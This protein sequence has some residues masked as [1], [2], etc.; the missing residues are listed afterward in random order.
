[1]ADLDKIKEAELIERARSGDAGSFSALVELYQQRAIHAANGLVGNLEDARDMAQEAFVKA[2][3][4]LDTFESQ[5]RFY[6]WFYRILVNTCRDFLRR[7][8][9]R[10]A[11]SFWLGKQEEADP[12]ANVA[13]R[14]ENA[15][16]AAE[17]RDLGR[18]VNEA[19]EKLPF[20]QR[21]VFALR[22]LEGQSLDEISQS[23]DIS[24]G[25]VKAH[26]WQACEKM[27]GILKDVWEGEQ[28]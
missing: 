3:E 14:A 1:V 17:H 18:V 27:R 11:F 16:D 10:G 25:A 26:L 7:Q 19:L 20:R 12:A 28:P 8:K 24:V 15:S 13:D 22:Y 2:Y 21:S 4:K 5:S 6:T 9:V 23:L